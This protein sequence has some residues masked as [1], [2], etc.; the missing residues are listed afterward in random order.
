MPEDWPPEG[1]ALAAAIERLLDQ[2]ELDREA[3]QLLGTVVDV[4]SA[5][6]GGGPELIAA[7]QGARAAVAVEY[8]KPIMM[9]GRYR[10]Q[11][12]RGSP[13]APASD[14]PASAWP[15]LSVNIAASQIREPDGTIWFDVRI[16]T[17]STQSLAPPLPAAIVPKS[18]F[19]TAKA[20]RN[21][22]FEN[23][24]AEPDP[25]I[26]NAG[27]V[28]EVIEF[29]RAHGFKNEKP[30]SVATR[31]AEHRRDRRR[32]LQEQLA[33]RPPQKPTNDPHRGK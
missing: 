26:A 23:H 13:A 33:R 19:E 21:W 20:C 25:D 31:Y 27:Y 10:A 12:R 8:F 5:L 30:P 18:G 15:Y 14:I 4:R 29:C 1:L 3:S 7:G 9:E 2:A 22:Y 11:G 6:A 24:P 32:V 28:Q 17:A 16:L